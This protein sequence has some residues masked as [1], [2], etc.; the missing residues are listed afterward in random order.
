ME[1]TLRSCIH[2]HQTFIPL[3]N[4]KQ[5]YCSQNICQNARKRQW[6]KQKHIDDPA[7]RQNQ[8]SA[9]QHWQRRH[10]GDWK[11]IVLPIQITHNA[12]VSSSVFVSNNAD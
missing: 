11:S 3:R 2:C 12:T 7:Y 6:R 5:Q 1:K 10:P 4:L 9:E 8:R